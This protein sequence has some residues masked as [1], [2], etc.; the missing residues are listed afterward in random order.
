[1]RVIAGEVSQVAGGIVTFRLRGRTGERIV[2][3]F[4]LDP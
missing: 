4:R 3:S 1:L 2:F